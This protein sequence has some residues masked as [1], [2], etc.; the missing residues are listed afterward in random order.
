MSMRT[1]QILCG[2][3]LLSC[4]LEVRAQDPEFSQYYASP[5]YLNPAFAGTS[6]DHRF[7][8]IHRNQWPSISQGYV[9]YALSY[10]YNFESLRSGLGV[11]VM[12]DKAG[13]ANLRSTQFNF[14]YSYKVNL[15]DRWILSSG[16]NFGLGQRSIDLNKL[17]FY[18][19]LEFDANGNVTSEDPAVRNLGNT[20]YFDFGGGIL[21][22]NRK[23]WFGFS[24]S[25]LN[26]PNRSLLDEEAIIPVKTSLHGGVRIPLYHGLFK[27][28]RIAAIAPSFI[29]KQQGEFDQ[30]DIGTYFL[31]EPIVAGLWYRGIPVKQK[32]NDNVSHDAVVVVLGFQLEKFELS[33][34]YDI[35]VSK[36]G[37]ISGGAHELALKFK[38][39]LATQIKTRKRERFIPCPTFIKD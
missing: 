28:D 25:H 3:I 37:P 9:T 39:D 27:K 29:Y 32:G 6:V 11:L 16:L 36:L 35:T 22:Y 4:C 13:T 8:A 17:L 10:D 12:T 30:L 33:Y 23:F 24:A 34:S 21:I 2:V 38:L 1:I 31:Y 14:Q 20:S 5:L 7:I 18:D 26:R 19:Q 15:N